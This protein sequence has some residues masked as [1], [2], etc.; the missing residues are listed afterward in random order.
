M[1]VEPSTL[2]AYYSEYHQSNELYQSTRHLFNAETFSKM[3]KSAIFINASRG[4]VVNQDA[5]VQALKSNTI[6]AAGL[7]VTDP[8]PLPLFVTAEM[9][10][11]LMN[12]TITQKSPIVW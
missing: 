7:D 10:F 5:L 12:L 1:S 9:P 11:L 3:K 6:A 4:G 8:E 2:G